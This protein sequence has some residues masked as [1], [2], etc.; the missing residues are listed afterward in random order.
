MFGKHCSVVITVNIAVWVG[1]RSRRSCY[2]NE[3][4][5]KRFSAIQ[6]HSTGQR[7]L[8][9]STV[10]SHQ[11]EAINTNALQLVCIG[12]Y[13]YSDQWMYDSACSSVCCDKASTYYLVH[14]KTVI[15]LP[16]VCLLASQTPL[17]CCATLL[18]NIYAIRGLLLVTIFGT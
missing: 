12:H 10:N 8:L 4:P 7:Q 13:H 1:G 17:H 2:E 11:W 5:I 9:F 15:L 3:K 16:F 18:L 14:S 6:W